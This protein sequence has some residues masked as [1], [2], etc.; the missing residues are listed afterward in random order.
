M[1]IFHS[2]VKLPEGMFFWSWT[3]DSSITSATEQ[4]PTNS[5]SPFRRVTWSQPSAYCGVQGSQNNKTQNVSRFQILK[6]FQTK[7]IM[8]WPPK[9]CIRTISIEQA[10]PVESPPAKRRQRDAC[11]VRHSPSQMRYTCGKGGYKWI[12][13]FS[14]HVE[15]ISYKPI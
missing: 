13:K 14:L 2:Y 10:L 7:I 15:Y 11:V 1:V 4:F 5:L 3:V 6:I 9:V 12:Q 8:L